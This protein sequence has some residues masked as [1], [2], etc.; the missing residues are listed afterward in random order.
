MHM[1]LIGLSN[2]INIVYI[3]EGVC[4]INYIFV[5]ICIYLYIECPWQILKH[6]LYIY[7]TTHVFGNLCNTHVYTCTC[8]CIL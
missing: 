8:T 6:V 1:I 5:Y 4:L 7:I 3:N 2:E